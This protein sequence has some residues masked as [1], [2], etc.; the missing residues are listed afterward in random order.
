M[1][2]LKR[3]PL[4]MPTP[5]TALPGRPDA[6]ATAATHFV[7]GAPL[8]GPYP[9]GSEIAIFGLGCFWGAEKAF[10]S[11][12]GRLR[13]RRRLCRR[14][15]RPIRPMRKCAR[16]AP[17]TPRSCSWSSIPKSVSY[18]Q[19]SR[20]SSRAT[21]R[22]RACARAMMS[23]RNTA[24]AST[25][26]R[27]DQRR[28]AEAAKRAY[29]EA[30]KAKG[31]GPITTEILPSADLLFRRRLSPAISCEEPAWL[32][33]PRRHRRVLPDRHGRYGWRLAPP[34]SFPRKRELIG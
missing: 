30:L 22:P 1:F 4:S 7:N 23:A 14:H 13:H 28:A 11:V 8:K 24:P 17:A 16:A 29:D 31:L 26:R 2:G 27:R 9:Q 5:E 15:R 21:T 34:L 20:S 10:W 33:W 12:A 25:S 6:I 18:E 32:L 3:K 19:L